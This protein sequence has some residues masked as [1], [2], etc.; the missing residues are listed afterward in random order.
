VVRPSLGEEMGRV[1]YL[2]VAYFLLSSLYILLNG[3]GHTSAGGG[4]SADDPAVDLLSLVVFALA[5]VDR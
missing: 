5:V 4:S 1:L 2:G 3:S